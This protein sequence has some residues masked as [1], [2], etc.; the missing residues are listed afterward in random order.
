MDNLEVV[1]ALLALGRDVGIEDDAA[2]V[3]A[4]EL[5]LC[6]VYLLLK[7]VQ[8]LL[9]V[10]RNVDLDLV[11]LVAEVAEHVQQ[12]DSVIFK[13]GD[14]LAVLVYVHR[15]ARVQHLRD[16]IVE[17]GKLRELARRQLR[18]Q[19]VFVGGLDVGKSRDA[20]GAAQ[21]LDLGDELRFPAVVPGGD[22]DGHLVV[23]AEQLLDALVGDLV[24]VMADGV[25]RI[26]R[27]DVVDAAGEHE[28]QHEQNREHGRHHEAR[29]IREAAEP[30]DLRD[31][32]AVVRPVDEAG[33]G[34]EQA[35]HQ[36]EH[37]AQ[38]QNDR[39]YHHDA[40]VVAQPVLHEGQRQK[41]GH[42]REAAGG[43]LRNGLTERGNGRLARGLVFVLL[44]VPVAEDDGVVDGH[45]ELEDDGDGVGDERYLP[46]HVVRAHVQQCRRAEG[47]Q[48]H[49]NFGVGFRGEQ[50][51]DD[52]YERRDAVNDEQLAVDYRFEGVADLGVDVEVVDAEHVA[53][54]VHGED[55]DLVIV[56]AVKG[57]GKERGGLVVM[58]R[59]VVKRDLLDA[60]HA[61]DIGADLLRLLVAHVLDD[62]ARGAE[63][64]ELI[65][66][67]F[68]A[69]LRLGALRQVLGQAVADLHPAG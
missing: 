53:Q 69:D 58:L 14:D 56:F 3:I 5:E 54:G 28:A 35:G 63:G 21:L 10:R 17:V 61:L 4:F 27:I 2:P 11:A 8:L 18:G 57:D 49:R 45:G 47:Y 36:Q 22:D 33:E 38:A 44:H 66:H 25:H 32:A 15:V 31:E 30:A 42:G 20:D 55:A 41:A 12:R 52:D 51:H 40:D 7:L 62:D 1:I 37:R 19:V 50:Q 39:L 29:L 13:I 6:V 64:R 46:H 23:D 59:T 67:E 43:D 9:G 26:V 24:F 60:G 16:L 68:E 34:H 48:Q 65:V